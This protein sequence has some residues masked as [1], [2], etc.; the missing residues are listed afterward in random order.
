MITEILNAEIEYLE[1]GIRIYN[2]ENKEGILLDNN[3]KL[4]DNEV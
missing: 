4:I 3:G 2:F 1:D